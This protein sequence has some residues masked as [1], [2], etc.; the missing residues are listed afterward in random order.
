MWKNPEPDASSGRVA[1][2]LCSGLQIRVR[3]FNSDLGLQSK[4]PRTR[5]FFFLFEEVERMRPWRAA[6]P[7]ARREY[8]HV[9]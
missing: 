7:E 8:V 2:W 3:R 6:E 4:A 9:G 5:G 1:E